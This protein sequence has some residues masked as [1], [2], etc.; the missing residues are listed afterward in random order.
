MTTRNLFDRPEL[1]DSQTR[2]IISANGQPRRLIRS[3]TRSARHHE[4]R[5]RSDSV[6]STS[7]TQEIDNDL[8][9]DNVENNTNESDFTK[10]ANEIN[11]DTD[12]E[13][14]KEISRDHTCK[15]IYINQCRRH[16]VIPSS[17]FLRH[18]DQDAL[19]IRYCGL[20]PMNVKVMVPALKINSI[21]T[22]LDLRDNG[23]GSRGA[24]YIAHVL[25]ENSYI[26]ELNLGN[27]DIGLQGMKRI[28]LRSD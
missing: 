24:V 18:I 8:S 4:L 20:R 23:L 3:A 12:I 16:G 17:Y 25:K 13:Q 15:G 28:F 27:N 22:K 2:L 6:A 19:I 11:Y 9:D 7:V 14:D 1:L 26:D 5:E 10:I 21:I